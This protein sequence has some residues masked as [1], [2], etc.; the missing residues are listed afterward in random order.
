LFFGVLVGFLFVV[1]SYIIYEWLNGGGGGG[2]S[3][4]NKG[5]RIALRSKV[6]ESVITGLSIVD[7]MLPMGRGQRRLVL[8]DINTSTLFSSVMSN[9]IYN[10]RTSFDIAV[11][12]N[13]GEQ[14][15]EGDMRSVVK[16]YGFGGLNIYLL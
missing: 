6:N 13:L 16:V 11:A 14:P 15:G 7:T 2:T 3:I 8:S 10:F 9:A 5:A 12:A 4:L 1:I